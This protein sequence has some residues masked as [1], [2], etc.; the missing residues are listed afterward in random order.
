MAEIKKD[1]GACRLILSVSRT[2]YTKGGIEQ[3]LA[4]ERLLDRRPDLIG[5]VR[6]MLVSVQAASAA[7]DAVQRDIEA[8][9]G[10]INGQFGSFEW[11]PVALLSTP[12]PFG[13][14]VSYYR[15]ADVCWITPLCDG[16]NLVA[17]EFIAVQ[18]EDADADVG[19]L[20]LSE[21]AGAAV[22]LGDAILV[23][24]FSHRA[25][26][27]AID[28]ALDMSA[29]ERRTRI[30]SLKRKVRELDI[31]S[32]ATEQKRV[33]SLI[34]RAQDDVVVPLGVRTAKRQAKSRPGGGAA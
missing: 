3:L 8:L 32:W 6:L 21:F 33:F 12:V 30:I 10:R 31:R 2:D 28:R 23:N 25:M 9:S 4:F 27:A 14:L 13:E 7:Y 29:A 26:D 17:S 1:L 15:A 20:V 24:P 22:E 18:Q 34:R 5:N 19:A 16:L 11:Q